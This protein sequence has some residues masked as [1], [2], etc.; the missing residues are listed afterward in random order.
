MVRLFIAAWWLSY[1]LETAYKYIE[2]HLLILILNIFFF[3]LE[4]VLDTMLYTVKANILNH[5]P[6]FLFSPLRTVRS[7]RYTS[8]V[9]RLHHWSVYLCSA[10]LRLCLH[11]LDYTVCWTL[12][13]DISWR[14]GQGQ[15][16]FLYQLPGGTS[17]VDIP[18]DYFWLSLEYFWFFD[19]PMLLLWILTA[20]WF[21]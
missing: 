13:S 12:V 4:S 21:F 7:A 1:R 20:Y 2:I 15:G 10:S 14:Q 11:L 17:P 3:L 8:H 6:S 5:S 19:C 16:H 18:G 9:L